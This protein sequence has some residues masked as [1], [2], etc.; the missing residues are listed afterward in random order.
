LGSLRFAN[1]DLSINIQ[2]MPVLKIKGSVGFLCQVDSENIR[3][4]QEIFPS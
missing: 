2:Q 4:D 3:P 1:I